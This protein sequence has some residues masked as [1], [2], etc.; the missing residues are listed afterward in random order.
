MQKKAIE[1][2]A[3]SSPE[4]EFLKNLSEN[5]G[6]ICCNMGCGVFNCDNC[7]LDSITDKCHDLANEINVFLAKTK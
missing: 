3:L 7:P 2:I 1:V 4:R 6:T 5:L